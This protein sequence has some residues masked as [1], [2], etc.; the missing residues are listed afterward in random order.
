MSTKTAVV[1]TAAI[2]FG[3]GVTGIL[4]GCRA[5]TPLPTIIKITS[6]DGQTCQQSIGGVMTPFVNVPHGGTVKWTGYVNA[7]PGTVT[8]A[9]SSPFPQPSYSF[10]ATTPNETGPVGSYDYKTVTLTLENG[11]NLTCNIRPGAMGLH[12]N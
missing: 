11:Q 9:G 2:A 7:A 6:P 5:A 4:T 1:V 3:V 8:F 10:G 12:V